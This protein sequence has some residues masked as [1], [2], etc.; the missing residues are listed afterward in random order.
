MQFGSRAWTPSL[1]A[2]GRYDLDRPTL[3][4]NDP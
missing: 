4:L 2:D 3:C 1:L